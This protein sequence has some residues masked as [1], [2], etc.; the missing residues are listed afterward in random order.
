M[1]N[2]VIIFGPW[3]G[4]FSYEISWWIPEIRFLRNNKFKDYHSI[5]V[6]YI[7]RGGLYK[8]FIDEYIPFT[9]K[10]HDRI[11]S[12]DCHLSR[13]NDDPR[14]GLQMP[15]DTLEYFNNIADDYTKKGHI[16]ETYTPM[17][18]PIDSNRVHSDNPIGEFK[19]LYPIKSIDEE[20]KKELRTFNNNRDIIAINARNRH[21]LL[22]GTK[23]LTTDADGQTW[24]QENWAH[25]ISRLIDELKV[26]VIAMGIPLRGQ[27]P[28]SYNFQENEYLK[29][30]VSEGDN[31]IEYQ[32]AILKNTK[33]CIWGS[34]G[35]ATLCFFTNTPLFTQQCK[36]NG[37]RLFFEWQ[38]RL[39][40]NH[41]NI[42]VFDKYT[43]D[44]LPDSSADELFEEFKK[45][46]IGIS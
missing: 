33:C 17:E 21:R 43:K 8:D 37:N 32:L 36:E 10:L 35:A 46:Y 7:G 15:L 39:T 24:K 14:S 23:E 4:E 11:D 2:K 30:F 27:Y 20:I 29:S 6:G 22:D 40:D 12:P 3:I 16:V 31:S 44:S 38:K 1:K 19:H 41:K 25:F 34:S 13:C 26:N 9:E 5:H 42:K 28:G 18:N 45:F